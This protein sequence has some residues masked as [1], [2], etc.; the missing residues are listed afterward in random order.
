MNVSYLEHD[1]DNFFACPRPLASPHLEDDAS[2]TPDINLEIVPLLLGIDD[3]RGH[4]ENSALHGGECTT[5]QIL[6]SF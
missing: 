4:P 2:D 3:L 6:R 1:G 5:L